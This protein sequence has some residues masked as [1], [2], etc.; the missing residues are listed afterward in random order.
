MCLR[1]S[2]ILLLVLL[3]SPARAQDEKLAGVVKAQ[4]KTMLDAVTAGDAKT[5]IS[6]THPKVVERLGG[7]EKATAKTKAMMDDVKAK[8][9]DFRMTELRQPAIAKNKG[10]YY[11]VAA[12]T[13]VIN[14]GT[15]RV[16]QKTAAIG[17][18]SDEG[19]TWKFINLDSE[20][21]A[22]IRR[23]LPDLPRELAIPKH[24]MTVET[25]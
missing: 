20:G 10:D 15:K 17:I 21:E 1:L 8:G 4:I 7:S 14:G 16:I 6:M 25:R 23:V 11:A 2:L 18:S 22:K 12:Y 13:L 9:N 19:K 3:T 5:V 24:T